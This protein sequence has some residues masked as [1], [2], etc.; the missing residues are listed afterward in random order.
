MRYSDGEEE[1]KEEEGL[2]H[3]ARVL[4][5]LCT[6]GELSSS[7]LCTTDTFLFMAS[8]RVTAKCQV[9]CQLKRK[10]FWYF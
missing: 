7:S 2:T 1:G 9:E 6:S 10:Y 3:F 4:F 5:F 8:A